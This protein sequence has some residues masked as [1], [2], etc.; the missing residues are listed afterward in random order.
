MSGKGRGL[1]ELASLA[2][3]LLQSQGPGEPLF[4]GELCVLVRRAI[5]RS[6]SSGV[7]G[8]LFS[9]SSGFSPGPGRRVVQ[10]G[11]SRQPVSQQSLAL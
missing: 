1:V 11:S 5:N 4:P 6:K 7:W 3:G 9:P 10:R 2:C 8:L